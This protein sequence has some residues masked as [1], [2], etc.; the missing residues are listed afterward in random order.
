M[1]QPLNGCFTALVTPFTSDGK[2]VDLDRLAEQI[3]F[4]ADAKVTGIVPCG[5]TGES[6]T[7]TLKEWEQVVVSAVEVGHQHELTVIAGTGSNNTVHA[8]DLQ[9]RA[10]GLGA[11]AGLSVVPYYNKPSQEGLYYHFMS[12]ADAV[13]LPIILYNIPGRSGVALT[14]ETILRLA[15]HPNIIAVKD[16]TGLVNSASQLI[17]LV[18]QDK[19][20]LTIL[21]GDDALTLPLASV[22]AQ[23]VIS[24]ISNILPGAMQNL[25]DLFLN[26]NWED[27]RQKHQQLEPVMRGLLSLAGNPI[28]IKMAMKLLGRDSGVLRLPM[29]AD[30]S[31]EEPLSTFLRQANLLE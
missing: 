8:I 6:P 4:Q 27:A 20:D 26:N 23:G 10:H 24:V 12:I 13:D 5:T 16:A 30:A 3:F 17:P 15:H 25:C 21:S 22:G 7:L 29:Y 2:E 9:K 1:V 14:V 31:I 18:D 28:P 19:L 11:D